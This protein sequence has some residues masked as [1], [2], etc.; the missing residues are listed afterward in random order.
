MNGQV[1]LVFVYG[2]AFHASS[3]TRNAVLGRRDFN[4]PGKWLPI[5]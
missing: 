1:C 3:S 5:W 2:Y 4:Q